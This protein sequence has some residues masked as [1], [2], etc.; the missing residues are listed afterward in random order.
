[1]SA[2]SSRERRELRR[3]AHA[4]R[5]VVHVGGRGLTD[6]VIEQVERALVDH[7]LIKVRISGDRADRRATAD[8][9]VKATGGTLAGLIGGVAIL[10]RPS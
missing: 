5:P 10:Y 4:L 1:M 2:S 7:E 8:A 9:I 3:R 6:A